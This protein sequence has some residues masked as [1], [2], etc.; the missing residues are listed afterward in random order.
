MSDAAGNGALLRRGVMLVVSSPSG[1]GKTTLTRRLMVEDDEISLSISVTTRAPR[2]GETDGTDYFFISENK[3]INMR[4][5]GELLESAEVFGHFYGTPRGP[6][7]AQLD[8]GRDVLFDIDWQ[9][10]QQIRDA[11]PSDFL[12]LF[13]LPPSG[14]AL[15]ERLVHRAQDS[16]D[17]IGRRMAGAAT[18]I[19]HWDEYDYVIVNDDLDTAYMEVCAVLRAGRLARHRRQDALAELVDGLD[20]QLRD[21]MGQG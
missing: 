18:E 11:M 20:R 19:S 21:V 7:E 10:A 14:R 8:A 15:Y 13:I 4:D 12:S 9:G 16:H 3:F 6:V 17:V 2:P 1:A 5:T